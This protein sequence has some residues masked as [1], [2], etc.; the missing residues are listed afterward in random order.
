MI[1]QFF[2][3]R[4]LQRKPLLE[5]LAYVA[6]VVDGVDIGLDTEFN[7]FFLVGHCLRLCCY[8][9]LLWV[10]FYIIQIVLITLFRQDYS[11]LGYLIRV[12]E[13]P[14]H[15]SLEHF[16]EERGVIVF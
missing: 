6:E 13:K 1:L 7:L 9:S 15:A 4:L 16:F 8:H 2:L 11:L 10:D 14:R 3:I 12:G 5:L